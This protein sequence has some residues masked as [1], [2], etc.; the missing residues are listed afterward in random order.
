MTDDKRAH[1]DLY[2][3]MTEKQ[4]K[5]FEEV[6]LSVFDEQKEK[7]VKW[8]DIHN[9]IGEGLF[10]DAE[11]A[12]R[13]QPII[14]LVYGEG[15]DAAIKEYINDTDLIW[16]EERAL[17]LAVSINTTTLNSIKLILAEGLKN[18]ESI[19]QIAK[20]IEGYFDTN[21]KMRATRLARTEVITA[22]NEGALNRYQKENIEMVEFY[23]AP[24]ACP[25]CTALI[26]EYPVKE[27]HGIITG[28]TH[29]NCRCVW[30]PVV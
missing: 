1:W 26:G 27:S 2:A 28:E 29:P 3:A 23:P 11:T 16:I 6:F 20:K 9:S 22:S 7:S 13:F 30:L 17:E 15:F 8:L 4:E 14:E 18:G 24:D 25:I 19:A 5:L 10:N 12:E 21:A